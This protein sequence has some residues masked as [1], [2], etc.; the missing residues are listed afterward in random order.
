MGKLIKDCKHCNAGSVIGMEKLKS[1]GFR[2]W[3]DAV[4]CK[5]SIEGRGDTMREALSDWNRKQN[6]PVWVASLDR[7]DRVIARPGRKKA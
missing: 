5:S 1:G 3:C 6:K 7:R 4:K 2:V